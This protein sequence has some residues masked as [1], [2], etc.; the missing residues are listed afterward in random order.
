MP[1]DG[2]VVR[3]RLGGR[4]VD[5]DRREPAGRQAAGRQ[6]LRRHAEP[7]RRAERPGDPDRRRHG[8]RP[9][10]RGRGAGAG[11]AGA[12]R[13]ARRRGQ[14]V[15]VP[16]VIG[17]ALLAFA[18][19]FAIDPTSSGFAVAVERFVAVLVIACPVCARPRDARRGRGRHRPRRRARHPRQGRRGARGRQPRRH[20]PARQDRHR[21]RGQA[22]PHRRRRAGA[23][24]GGRAARAVAAL[25]RASEH[26]VAR[27]I[28]DGARARGATP[29]GDADQFHAEA[30]AGVS[31]MVD[32][33]QHP[34]RHRGVARHGRYRRDAPRGTAE[35][36]AAR[37]RTPSFVSIDGVLAGLVAVADR[38]TVEAARAIAELEAAGHRGGD[39]HRRPGDDRPCRR[40]RAGH[41]ARVR[42]GPSRGQGAH[43]RGGARARP[44]RRD[45]RRRHQRR[46]R[47]RRR[48]RRHRDRH[49]RRHRRG[50]RRHRAAARRH[51]A[52]CLR[53]LRLARATLRTIRQNLFWAFVYNVVGIPIAAG[54]LYR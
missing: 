17:L 26:P 34:R 3:G 46:S 36:V 51:R 6:R 43:R 9:D 28:V 30:G 48:R 53:A 24:R 50:R 1:A 16:I 39:G 44:D 35:A 12:D 11:L 8:A 4:R 52:R 47:P 49:R 23:V 31:G 2:E 15:F 45:G 7:E 20:G 10:R 21:H 5:A 13:A 42:R 14:R 19:W 22:Q 54:A 32:G 33:A 29:H 18:V 40:A 37:G 25:E 41:R 38:P 27:A